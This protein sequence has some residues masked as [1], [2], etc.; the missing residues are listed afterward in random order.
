[1]I[2]QLQQPL[3]FCMVCNCSAIEWECCNKLPEIRLVL[4]VLG[5]KRNYRT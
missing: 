4:G 2:F 3:S 1:M 5:S